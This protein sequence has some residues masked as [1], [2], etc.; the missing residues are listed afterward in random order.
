MTDCRPGRLAASGPERADQSDPVHAVGLG[1]GDPEFATCRALSL[2]ED[3]DVV[4]GFK[5]V[6]DR[7][8]DRTAADVLACGYDDQTKVLERF[9]TRVAGGDRGVAVLWGDPN[10][11]GYQFLGRVEAA[12]D[13]PV[14]VCPGVSSLQ[15]AASRA[16]TPIE[17]SAV[18][19]LHRRGDVSGDF[20]RLATAAANDRHLLVLVRPYDWMP[21]AIATALRERGV[22]P[23]RDALVLEELTLPGES[24][25]RT[26]VGALATVD[27]PTRHGYSD[28]TILVV[29]APDSY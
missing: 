27:A 23:G 21:P 12:L 19:S 17:H 6:T 22:D 18:G 3:A 9:A 15:I 8:T 16:R 28:R 7:I 25:E 14:R 5:T 29:R 13:G 10:V 4:T 2:I 20:E 1:P 26:T 24:I 11:S